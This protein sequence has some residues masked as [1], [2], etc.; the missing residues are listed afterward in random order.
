MQES[1]KRILEGNFDYE[2]GSL[3]FSCTKLELFLPKGSVY[4][5]SFHITATSNSYTKG[6]ITTSDARMEC[7][8]PEFVG[9]DVEIPFCFHGENMEEGDV[10]K[11]TFSIVS[12]QGEYYLP[13]VV[14]IE[15][16][17][18]SS[19]VGNV[20]NLFHFANLA[21]S[22]WREAVNLFYSPDFPRVFVGSDAQLYDCY[23]ALCREMNR[24]WKN[25]LFE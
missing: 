16:M 1:V 24:I 19:S 3:D 11:G 9:N 12:N 18:L 5:G 20:K 23:R 4:E 10:L 13:F 7:L 22:N 8:M 6:Y 2:N 21:K 17:V 15:Y 25:S 14:S